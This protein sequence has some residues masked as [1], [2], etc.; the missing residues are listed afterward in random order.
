MVYLYVCIVC[1]CAIF[2]SFRIRGDVFVLSVGRRGADDSDANA[3]EDS[4][5]ILPRA[6]PNR[7]SIIAM[8]HRVPG[9]WETK[10]PC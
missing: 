6:A 2:T 9:R 3:C 7:K 5:Y 4:L 8:R 10:H 1:V